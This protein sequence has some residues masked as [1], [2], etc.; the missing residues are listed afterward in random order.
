MKGFTVVT[1]SRHASVKDILDR[2]R[3]IVPSDRRYCVPVILLVVTEDCV[4][5]TE[6]HILVKLGG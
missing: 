4:V 5:A 2:L 3:S 6:L 1:L